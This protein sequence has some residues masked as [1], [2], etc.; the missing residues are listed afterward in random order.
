MFYA[1][2]MATG[3]LTEPPF[4]STGTGGLLSVFQLQTLLFGVLIIVFLTLEP[5]GL[6][7]LWHRVRTY[8]TTWPFSY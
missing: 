4:V 6:F 2:E 3:N 7:G 1:V 5:R 8:F